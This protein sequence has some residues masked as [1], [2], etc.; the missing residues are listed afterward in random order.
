MNDMVFPEEY[1]VSGWYKWSGVVPT[2]GTYLGWRLTINKP[3]VT[4]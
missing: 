2:T 3:K 4:L 1:A